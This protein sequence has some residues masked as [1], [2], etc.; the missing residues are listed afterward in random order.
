VPLLLSS[1][2][3]GT[4]KAFERSLLTPAAVSSI[5]NETFTIDTSKDNSSDDGPSSGCL[6]GVDTLSSAKDRGDASRDFVSADHTTFV[7]EELNNNP[8][9]AQEFDQVKKTLSTC[10]SSILDGASMTIQP[11]SAPQVA[12]IDDAMA[13]GMTG[14]IN[15]TTISF[16]FAFVRLGDN[17]VAMIS[18]GIDSSTDLQMLSNSLLTEA[19]N[20]ARPAL[21]KS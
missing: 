4:T 7:S 17:V 15:G 21:P 10:T 11:L 12:G 13:V 9:N 8:S 18:G 1:G 19:V 14:Q 5:A 16:D 3:S 6:N 2:K 20:T